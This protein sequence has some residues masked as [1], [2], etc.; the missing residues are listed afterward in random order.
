MESTH[1]KLELFTRDR[2]PELFEAVGTDPE[3]YQWLP[4]AAPQNFEE[5][6]KVIEGYIRDSENG[7]R[8]MYV[9]ILKSTGIAIGT[10]SFLDLNLTHKSLEVGST[11][12]SKDYWRSFVNTECKL[13]ML[14]EAFEVRSVERVM[15]K[16]DSMNKRSRDAIARLGAT[17]EGIL[18]HH[19]NRPDG[20]WRDSAYHSIL[21]EEWPDVKLGLI[22]KL[23]SHA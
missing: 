21:Q 20:T 19:M 3:I 7:I 14:T 22:N 1:L 17:F 23:N 11:F 9:V 18:R 2:I 16:T 6:A 4:F 8:V 12:Y 10:T 5:F 15:I 13:M